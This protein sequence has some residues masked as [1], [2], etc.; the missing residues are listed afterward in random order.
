MTCADARDLVLAHQRG[1]LPPG[2]DTAVREHLA[3]CSACT[4]ADGAERMLTEV[5]EQRLP[6]HPAS[7]ALKRRLAAEWPE[8]PRVRRSFKRLWLPAL[9]AA[10]VVLVAMPLLYQRLVVVP[11]QR[12]A[13][14]AEAVNDHVRVLLSQ[15]PMEAE[16]S[17]MHQVKP[18]FAGRLDFAPVVA[19]S[20]D[21]EFPLRGGAVGYFLDRRAAVFLYSRRLHAISLFVVR[22]DG[23]DWPERRLEMSSRGFRVILWRAG[24]LGYALVSDVDMGELRTLVAKVRGEPA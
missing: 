2:E 18:W 5:L 11:A 1:A 12:N 24:E 8:T 23:L 20:G 9:A 13:L 21:A 22:A 15:R 7:L 14:V 10:A 16:S 6:Q 3:S 17:D 4:R 19:F